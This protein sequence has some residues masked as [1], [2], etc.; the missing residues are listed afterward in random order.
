[1]FVSIAD[2]FLVVESDVIFEE[3]E[4]QD[5]VL[6]VS[7]ELNG[8][9]KKMLIFH[10]AACS[11]HYWRYVCTYILV[12]GNKASSPLRYYLSHSPRLG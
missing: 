12:V 4:V 5:Q 3:Y 10:H 6:D 1:M 2:S 8:I 7:L 11:Q 9:Q